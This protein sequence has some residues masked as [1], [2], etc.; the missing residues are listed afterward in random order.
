MAVV[1]AVAVVAAF[2]MI[3]APLLISPH[4]HHLLILIRS[5]AWQLIHKQNRVALRRDNKAEVL[6]PE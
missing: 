3:L 5:M 1:V 2:M 4:Y 6:Y